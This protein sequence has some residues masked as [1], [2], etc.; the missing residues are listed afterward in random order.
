IG[1]G[2]EKPTLL[3]LVE[4]LEIKNEVEFTGFAKDVS[5]YVNQ[6]D[7]YINS[8]YSEALPISVLEALS[9]GKPIIAS[10]VGGL[11]EIVEDG[12]NGILLDFNDLKEACRKLKEFLELSQ[13][14]Y[15]RFSRNA[16]TSFQEKFSNTN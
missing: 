11:P 6:L 9:I 15:F 13:N 14:D 12:F 7:Y 1:D 4:E 3:Q 2:P 5:P 16:E 10:N 8:S